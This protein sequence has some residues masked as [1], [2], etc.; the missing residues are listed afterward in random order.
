M[1]D[2]NAI[3]QIVDD[4]IELKDRRRFPLSELAKMFHVDERTIR[5]WV[6]KESVPQPVYVPMIQKLIEIDKEKAK[7]YKDIK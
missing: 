2:L 1:K 4:L 3:R 7:N 6:N 5:R